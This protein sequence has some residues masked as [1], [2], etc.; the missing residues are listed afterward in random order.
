[1]M[2]GI[3]PFEVEPTSVCEFYHIV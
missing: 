3:N 1:M 2:E